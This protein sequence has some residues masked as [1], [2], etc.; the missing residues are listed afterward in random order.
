[1]AVT[2]KFSADN[3]SGYLAFMG[4]PS[5]RRLL[6]TDGGHDA[7]HIVDMVAGIHEGY[8][9]APGTLVG[10]TGV[11]ARG[12]LVAIGTWEHVRDQMIHVFEG[13]GTTW[14]KSRKVGGFRDPSIGCGHLC[15]YCGLRFNTDGTKLVVTDWYNN[16]VSMFRVHDGSFERHVITDIDSP[17]DV[18]E[19]D[20]GWLVTGATMDEIKFVADAE[21]DGDLSNKE[22]GTS[23]GLLRP[24]SLALVPGVGLF[25]RNV[26]TS[27]VNMFVT[28]NSIA[29]ERMSDVRV[30]WMAAVARGTEARRRRAGVVRAEGSSGKRPRV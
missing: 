3:Y 25:V 22:V 13:S 9:A 30:Q 2:F 15:S 14:S 12:N 18:E 7:V 1:M 10:P 17:Q 4:P 8:V 21:V 29:M 16:R 27:S 28:H 20:G 24:T 26:G 5:C 11:A 19:W 6:V 23:W